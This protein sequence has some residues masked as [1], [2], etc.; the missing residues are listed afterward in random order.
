MVHSQRERRRWHHS[1]RID[2]S[3]LRPG[4]L[5]LCRI[6]EHRSLYKRSWSIYPGGMDQPSDILCS[7]GASVTIIV[8]AAAFG[9]VDP[10]PGVYKTVQVQEQAAAQNITVNGQAITV[11]ALSNSSTCNLVATPSSFSFSNTT[12]G[13]TLSNP[14]SI[15]SNCS[16]TVTINTV[17]SSGPPFSASGFQTP[18]SLAPG[19]STSFTA[20]FAPT[21]TGTFTGTLA[22]GSNSSGVQSVSVTLTGTGVAVQQ[23][24][25]SSSPTTLSFGSVAINNTQSQ[26]V[27]I[28]NTGAASVAVSAVGV[29]GTGFSLPNPVAPFTL[30]V[31]KSMQLAVV[32]AP[33]TTGSTTGNLKITSN[34]Q[35]GT[36]TVP[37]SGTGTSIVHSVAL[38]WADAA[39][40]ISGYNVY[41][42]TVSNGPY[43]RINAASVVPTSYSD[44]TVVSGTTYF[45]VVTAVGTNGVESTYSN[46]ATAQVP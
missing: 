29:S 30:G 10:L 16:K 21:S 41:R 11:P 26:T 33:T 14:G 4:G 19:Q 18:F 32:F 36:L 31:G 20:I 45:Y 34:A 12:V 1:H 46:Q 13:F 3:S 24:A 17:Q 7:L 25:L 15:A 38:S 9:G 27:T 22:F 42:S 28:T 6:N 5:N 8:G 44:L 23:G 39:S 43:T 37:L 2:Y 35:N 40:Q